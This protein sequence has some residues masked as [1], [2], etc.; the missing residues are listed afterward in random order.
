M[1]S[2][3]YQAR[4]NFVISVTAQVVSVGFIALVSRLL[5]RVDFGYYIWITALPGM[6]VVFDLYLGQALQNRLSELIVTNDRNARD[7][8]IWGF[9]WGML[10]ITLVFIAVCA[11]VAFVMTSTSIWH[12]ATIPSQV[13]WLGVIYVAAAGFGVPLLVAGTGFNAGG[14]VH[15]GAAF[16]LGLDLLTKLAFVGVLATTKSFFFAI[17]ILSI[18]TVVSNVIITIWFM[19]IF[20][21]VYLAPSFTVIKTAFRE[22]WFLGNA[23]EWA[24]LRV[25]DGFFKNSELVIGAFVISSATIGDFAVLDRLSTALMLAAN[26]AYVVLGPTLAAAGARGDKGRMAALTK[27]V[28]QFS[29]VGL[30]LFSV[31]FLTAG[32]WVASLWSGRAIDF[33]FLIVLLICARAWTRV[34]SSLYWNI[35]F[36]YKLVRGLLQATLMSGLAYVVLYGALI[37]RYGVLSILIAQIVAQAIFLLVAWRLQAKYHLVVSPTV[38]SAA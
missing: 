9:L 20:D 34:L 37:S 4:W 38:A 29:L 18:L 12:M 23:R 13:I 17:T 26:S 31:L 25:A 19:R 2:F 35:L 8:L 36:G 28:G 7:K 21:V 5:G 27:K 10:V 11:L 22:L 6:I 16:G 32:E 33:P 1:K 15:R 14:Q 24:V 30:V 3:S